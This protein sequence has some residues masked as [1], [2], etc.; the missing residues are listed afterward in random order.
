MKKNYQMEDFWFYV[1]QIQEEVEKEVLKQV[2][3]D[4]YFPCMRTITDYM[5]CLK[6]THI[7]RI[8]LYNKGQNKY[9][10]LINE[11]LKTRNIFICSD[12]I[13]IAFY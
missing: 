1:A 4:E 11:A 5:Y 3:E 8:A 10:P 13:S 2:T 7:D 12:Y 9:I 6:A